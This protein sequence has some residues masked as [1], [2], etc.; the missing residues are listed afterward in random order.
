MFIYCCALE[1]TEG[2]ERPTGLILPISSL[3]Y[4]LANYKVIT[5][6]LGFLMSSTILN[7]WIV[8]NVYLITWNG[9]YQGFI[10]GL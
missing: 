10:H 2:F 3:L 5:L 4:N 9:I 6:E 8:M 7:S 1:Q